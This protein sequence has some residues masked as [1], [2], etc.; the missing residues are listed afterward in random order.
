MADDT[1]AQADEA[2]SGPDSMA[3]AMAA[4]M[5]EG[6]DAAA[7]E[8][9]KGEGAPPDRRAVH[10]RG[11]HTVRPHGRHDHRN[12]L[13]QPRPTDRADGGGDRAPDLG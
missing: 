8:L 2:P 13:R 4:A 5:V 3:A 11:V 6:D 10:P 9:V 1:G 12:P 7:D